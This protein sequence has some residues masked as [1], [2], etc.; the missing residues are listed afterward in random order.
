MVVEVNNLVAGAPS[1]MSDERLVRHLAENALP[2]NEI[3]AIANLM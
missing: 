1:I 2:L 3:A